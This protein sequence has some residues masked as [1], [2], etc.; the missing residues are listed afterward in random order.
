MKLS[1][2][3]SEE[4]KIKAKE[5]LNEDL[6]SKVI[7]ASPETKALYDHFKKTDWM[8]K[9]ADDNKYYKAGEEH[10]KK[11]RDMIEKMKKGPFA[12]EAKFIFLYFLKKEEGWFPINMRNFDRL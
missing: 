2:I 1:D 12:K 11:T 9:M 3:I 5:L 4:V 6:N 7:N 10:W 8:Y